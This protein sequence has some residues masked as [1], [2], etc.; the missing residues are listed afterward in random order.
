MPSSPLVVAPDGSL[1]RVLLDL[2]GGGLAQFTLPPGQTSQAVYHR[3]VEE[4]WFIMSGQGQMWRRLGK[5]DETV[6]LQAGV[7]L[8]IPVGTRFQ[9]R[10]LGTDALTV[11]GVTMPP[12][13]GDGEAVGCQG[14]WGPTLALVRASLNPTPG[15]QRNRDPPRRVPFAAPSSL[16]TR[17]TTR[18]TQT[19]SSARACSIAPCRAHF[20]GKLAMMVPGQVAEF[21]E[22]GFVV[23]RGCFDPAPLGAEIDRAFAEG[24]LP[25]SGLT[26]LSQ[27]TG[28]VS[29]RYLPMMCERTPVSLGLLDRL[30]AVAG[31]LLGREVLPGRVKGTRVFRG[32]RVAPR[33]RTRPGDDG[34]PGLPRAA[35]NP[36]GCATRHAGIACVP[37]SSSPDQLRG[38]SGRPWPSNRH[39]AGRRGRLRRTPGPR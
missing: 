3:T 28:E 10:S 39:A 18:V 32:H 31:E 27:G 6:P 2:P 9:F 23:L 21:R 4:I 29:F 5:H 7:C 13:P 35:H 36:D 25:A 8:T 11:V 12:W 1:V 16:Y 37:L 20:A 22:N 34:F 19:S 38:G 17:R 24:F 14:P 30:A 33:Q 15:P 26:V